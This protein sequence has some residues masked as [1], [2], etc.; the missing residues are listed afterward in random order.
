[1]QGRGIRAI[2]IDTLIPALTEQYSAFY[3]VMASAE[4]EGIP[5]AEEIFEIPAKDLVKLRE[6]GR[7]MFL[8]FRSTEPPYI[9]LLHMNREKNIYTLSL[10]SL[11]WYKEM[12]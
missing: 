2:C 4:D 10:L 12:T 1:M 7:G 5:S 11:N 8:L 9:G 3:I 6:I